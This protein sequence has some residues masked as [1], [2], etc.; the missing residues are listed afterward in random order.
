M[1]VAGRA[2]RRGGPAC[3]WVRGLAVSWCSQPAMPAASSA[4][5]PRRIDLRV[6]GGE[7]PKS[8]A[9]LGVAG[10]VGRAVHIRRKDA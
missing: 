3:R 2:R 4:S 8:G 5:Q 6:F 7:M 10:W 1:V 9:E